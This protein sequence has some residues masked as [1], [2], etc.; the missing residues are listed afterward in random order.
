MKL[1]AY[2]DSG[3]VLT[4]GRG[5]THG[6]TAGMTITHDQAVAFL[7]EDQ[8]PLLKL[9]ADKPPL[10]GAAYASFG[11]NCGA[12]AL[13]AVLTGIDTLANPKHCT[14]KHGVVLPGLVSRRALEQLLIA[15]A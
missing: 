6:V 10:A 7:A 4:I 14:D 15:A 1:E 12:G 5:H 11:F 2:R 8:A 13:H 3:G 9:V